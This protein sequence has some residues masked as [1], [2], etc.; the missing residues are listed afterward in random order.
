MVGKVSASEWMTEETISGYFID[1]NVETRIW[2]AR[3]WEFDAHIKHEDGPSHAFFAVIL[4]SQL[5]RDPVTGLDNIFLRVSNGKYSTGEYWYVDPV[6]QSLKL[7]YRQDDYDIEDEEMEWMTPTGECRWR[8]LDDT[9]ALLEDAFAVI[10]VTDDVRHG[11]DNRTPG[12]S[13]DCRLKDKLKAGLFR[14]VEPTVNLTMGGEFFNSRNCI[15]S[16]TCETLAG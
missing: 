15:G 12:N 5:C 13:F 1:K 3:S 14:T 10:G 2:I 16:E 8:D 7:A 11:Y 6:S 9:R 4:T